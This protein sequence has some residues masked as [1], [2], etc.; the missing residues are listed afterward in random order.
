MMLLVANT[1]NVAADIAAMGE[2]LR[3]VIGGSAHVYAVLFGIA[4]LTLEVF[5]RVRI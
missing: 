3:L 2:S 5:L 1:I 4:C